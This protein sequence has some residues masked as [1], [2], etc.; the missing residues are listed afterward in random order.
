MVSTPSAAFTLNDFNS[1][2]EDSEVEQWMT[3]QTSVIPGVVSFSQVLDTIVQPSTRYTLSIDVSAIANEITN[4]P[5]SSSTSYRLEILI[6]DVVW[7]S[8]LNPLLLSDGKSARFTLSTLIP[9]TKTL[10]QYGLVD[11]K[12][13]V[14]LV[15][16]NVAPQV[17]VK[18]ENLQLVSESAQSAS[19][20]KIQNSSFEKSN[21]KDGE[22]VL[23]VPQGWKEYDPNQLIS[24]RPRVGS[25]AIGLANPTQAMFYG[26]ASDG[27]DTAFVSL[28][29]A[30]GTGGAGITQVLGERLQANTRYTVKVNV[31]NPQGINF[32]GRDL[33]GFSGYRI[34]L[35][36]GDRVL[37]VDHNT[38]KIQEGTFATSEV[39]FTVGNYHDLLR[40]KLSVRLINLNESAGT[41]V[42]FDAV[43]LS[44][45]KVADGSRVYIENAGFE[46]P[47]LPLD[48]FTSSLVNVNAIP[49]WQIYDPDGLIAR[50]PVVDP[51]SGDAPQVGVYR[52]SDPGTFPG[53]IPEGNNIADGGYIP[54]YEGG[55]LRV[56]DG[57]VGIFQTLDTVLAPNT[58][59]TLK[60]EVG[61]P[62]SVTVA[63]FF[64]P[65]DG[66]P[67]Y[68]VEL[69][70]GDQILAVDNNTLAP[71]DGT[72]ATSTVTYTSSAN[73][74]NLG[75]NLGIRFINL[76]QA[77]GSEVDY[78]DVRLFA[79][80]IRGASH[81]GASWM[82]AGLNDRASTVL[83][84]PLHIGN[85]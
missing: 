3:R 78:D 72:F 63:G 23:R 38:L 74:S 53:G 52:L 13:G 76:N 29:N 8:I 5:S 64:Y 81:R 71:A 54:T 66:F 69:L 7:D 44:F 33:N 75:K 21:L 19:F 65:L 70:A 67:G 6:G 56:G 18:A 60:V 48:T 80:P 2:G 37:A 62:Q 58:Q 16:N 84:S 12:I 4:L 32:D 79:E 11:Q 57:R 36:A 45:E 22:V 82:N 42:D 61:N 26:E 59:Y 20:A 34:E 50:F 15:T 43:K 24:E 30:P 1:G 49:G 31:G 51:V 46:N 28:T 17:T 47:G 85:S 10:G 35:L 9:D 25:S 73:D 55:P 83:T 68:R 14:R 39:D 27:A 41:R 77:P 40:E